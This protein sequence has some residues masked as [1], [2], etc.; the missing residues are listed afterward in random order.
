MLSKLFAGL[1]AQ[2]LCTD[3][4]VKTK[5]ISYVMVETETVQNGKSFKSMF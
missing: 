5:K 3:C 4:F 1:R 2:H